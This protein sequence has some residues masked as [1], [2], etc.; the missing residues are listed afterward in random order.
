MRKKLIFFSVLFACTGVFYSCSENHEESL[1]V[2]QSVRSQLTSLGFDLIKHPPIAVDNG[3]IVEGD[4]FLTQSDMDN[5]KPATRV[6]VAEQY[7]TNQLVTGL[8]RTITV[9]IPTS[10]FSATYVSALDEAISRYNALNLQ[11]HFQRVTSSTG[12]SMKFTRLAKSQERQGVLG[13]SG[14]PTSSGSPYGTIQMSGVL[15]ST[16]HLTV[17]GIATIMAHE[18]GHCI[19]FRHTDY[20]NRAISCGGSASNEGASTV[21]ANLIPGTPSTATLAAA[22]WMLACTDG[23]NRYFNNDDK[24]ALNY[25]Y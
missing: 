15:E 8:P 17:N 13:S 9:Y 10:S 7:S 22:S 19:G 18:M 20:Y 16:Y 23:S 3:Y 12:A 21:G 4:I 14:F 25:L 24:T 1:T 5:M 6:A 11:L 2:S